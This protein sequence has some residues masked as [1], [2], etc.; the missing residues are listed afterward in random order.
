[1]VKSL[2]KNIRKIKFPNLQIEI[3]ISCKVNPTESYDIIIKSIN[4]LFEGIKLEFRYG[5]RI[6]GKSKNLEVLNVIYN[7][8]RDRYIT[9]VLRRLLLSNLYECSTWF[10]INKQAAT[11]EVMVLVEDESE[12]PLGPIRI[13]LKSNNIE[14]VIEWLCPE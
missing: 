4:S 14:R 2:Q 3:E 12:S 13:N 9:S 11:K 10:Y 8:A 5:D 1:M 6:I 7:Q